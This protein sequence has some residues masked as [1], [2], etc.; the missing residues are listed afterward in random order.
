MADNEQALGYESQTAFGTP[1]TVTT[2]KY[3][4]R[5]F[6]NPSRVES[7]S[8]HYKTNTAFNQTSVDVRTR[9]GEVTVNL[10]VTPANI[11]PLCES[12]LGPAASGV[13]KA[14]V[15]VI[16]YLTVKFV[17]GLAQYWLAQD[18]RVNT[19][20]IIY[21]VTDGL[22]ANAQLLGPAPDVT[23][24]AWS[25]AAV[26][27]TANVPFRNWQV[28]LNLAGTAYCV[29]RFRVLVDN[30]LDPLYCSPSA[31]PT[32]TTLA[33]LTPNRY[34]RGDGEVT[35]EIEAKYDADAA[36]EYYK[37]RHQTVSTG[38]QLHA[39]DPATSA[40]ASFQLD[41]H[42][43]G[44]TDGEVQRENTNWQH[45]TGFALLDNTAGTVLTATIVQ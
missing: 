11:L 43:L 38:W 28:F 27:P 6:A 30:K 21:N 20:E 39:I 19:L 7:D 12:G 25:T 17:E 42:R 5:D 32:D 35:V 15:G 41:V 34:V 45:M 16:K 36:S 18:H 14:G 31:L 3:G 40:T 10:D 4:V 44:Y 9:Q 33:G 24:S 1:A 23:A 29:R 13:C 26:V 37:F 2:P 22:Q 8:P